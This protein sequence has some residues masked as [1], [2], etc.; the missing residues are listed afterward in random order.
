MEW[1]QFFG[2]EPIT[3]IPALRAG[4]RLAITFIEIIKSCGVAI[5]KYIPQLSWF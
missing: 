3:I 4:T 2:R 5:R 1:D